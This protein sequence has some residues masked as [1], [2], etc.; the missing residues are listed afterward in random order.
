MWHIHFHCGGTSSPFG[1]NVSLDAFLSVN[2]LN[3]LTDLGMNQLN[4]RLPISLVKSLP[5]ILTPV[6]DVLSK[7]VSCLQGQTTDQKDQ[8]KEYCFVFAMRISGTSSFKSD[9]ISRHHNATTLKC[10]HDSTTTSSSSSSP[11]PP[12][13]PPPP[14]PPPPPL[15]LPQHSPY[16]CCLSQ[17]H[18]LHHAESVW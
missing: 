12:P 7:E 16:S 9:K 14:P 10:L 1:P 4:S 2:S 17:E 18:P 11:P 8:R 6:C 5:V 15:S 3:E 13:L